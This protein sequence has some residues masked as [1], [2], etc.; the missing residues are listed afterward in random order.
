MHGCIAGDPM[1]MARF[2][3]WV[4]RVSQETT[5]HKRQPASDV[6]IL[7]GKWDLS[8]RCQQCQTIHSSNDRLYGTPVPSYTTLLRPPGM[9]C[10]AGPEH[11]FLGFSVGL[12]MGLPYGC[13]KFM[14]DAAPDSVATT[15]VSIHFRM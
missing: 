6:V 10:A 14:R 7:D 8:V 13:S 11:S 4:G 5:S 12:G 9:H 15:W 3:H 2:I 1:C